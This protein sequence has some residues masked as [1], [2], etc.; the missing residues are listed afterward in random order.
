MPKYECLIQLI[1]HV[2]RI[3]DLTSDPVQTALGIQH[4]APGKRGGKISIWFKE[5]IFG[6]DN[7]IGVTKSITLTSP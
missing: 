1:E 4:D 6:Q 7:F 5:L 3:F 2:R